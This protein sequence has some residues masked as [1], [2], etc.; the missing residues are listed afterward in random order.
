MLKWVTNSSTIIILCKYLHTHILN[1]HVILS[2]YFHI[3]QSCCQGILPP[4][5]EYDLHT[6]TL[7]HC[8]FLVAVLGQVIHFCHIV[9]V[10]GTVMSIPPPHTG[11][12][13]WVLTFQSLCVFVPRTH[14]IR[15]TFQHPGCCLS[16]WTELTP[17]HQG[18]DHC[19][20]VCALFCSG[21]HT[22]CPP[23]PGWRVLYLTQLRKT[24]SS[25]FARLEW[26]GCCQG[27]WFAV[28]KQ[29]IN[30]G[31]KESSRLPSRAPA[32]TLGDFGTVKGEGLLCWGAGLIS[33]GFDGEKI[34]T[35]V[36][37]LGWVFLAQQVHRCLVAGHNYSWK[38]GKI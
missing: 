20:N 22:H 21:L 31:T 29:L 4:P 17:P 19:S 8:D 35:R 26:I 15:F 24:S 6:K 9:E 32:I 5:L 3:I 1:T 37:R 34:Q 36:D 25:C 33:G 11:I 38:K 10:N 18:G 23:T 13:W 27:T 16:F 2:S 30:R 14:L 12:E 7:F 28:W